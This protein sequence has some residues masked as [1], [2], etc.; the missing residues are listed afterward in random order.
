MI[1]LYT[2]S[3]SN[4]F[5]TQIGD[6]N[7]H[8][9]YWDQ[10][11]FSNDDYLTLGVDHVPLFCGRTA[12]HCYEDFRYPAHPFGDGRWKFP[13]IGEFQ[14]YD[15]YMMGDLKSAASKEGNLSGKRRDHKRLAV[16]TVSHLT[17]LSLERERKVLF[18]I[19]GACLIISHEKFLHS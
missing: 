6:Q 14:S 15:K 12:L 7:K 16:T 2:K 8:I 4:W 10:N 1:D 9:Y 3:F 5:P 19:M 11:G 18:L 13:G 17:F